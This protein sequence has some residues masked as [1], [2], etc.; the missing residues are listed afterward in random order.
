MVGEENAASWVLVAC[1]IV[2]AVLV[3]EYLLVWEIS[4]QLLNWSS[5]LDHGYYFYLLL[6]EFWFEKNCR[7]YMTLV[8]S[9]FHGLRHQRILSQLLTDFEGY[10]H[11]Y[12][13]R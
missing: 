1:Q 3:D 9:L 11:S 13:D 12:A 8:E 5:L 7:V 2:D 4:L 10:C 6:R